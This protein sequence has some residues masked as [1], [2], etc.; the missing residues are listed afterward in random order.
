MDQQI[1]DFIHSQRICVLALEMLDGS[2]HAATLH[3]AI[4][5]EP[6]MF[7]FK[8]HRSYRKCEPLFG[9]DI[10]RASIVVGF[11]E[12]NMKTLQ[13]DGTARRITADMEKNLFDEVY[14]G[15][16]PEKNKGG[17]DPDAVVFS[18]VPTWWR[19]TDWHGPNG[20]LIITSEDKII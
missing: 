4:S 10:T 9:K 18:F 6:L 16:F 19:Y 17:D 7:F 12:N 2:P 5:E 3:F 11:D 20:K 1:I 13:L 15:K 14:L 8:T